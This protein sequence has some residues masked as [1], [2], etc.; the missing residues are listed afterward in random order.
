VNEILNTCKIYDLAMLVE[1]D[2]RKPS[3]YAIP[4]IDAM[5]TLSSIDDN[6][7]LDSGAEI[8]ARFLGNAQTW[9]GET[10]RRVKAELNSRLAATYTSKC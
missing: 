5:L 3:S 6:Y 10:A 4:Y 9:R 7:F 8:V 2:W 1:Q